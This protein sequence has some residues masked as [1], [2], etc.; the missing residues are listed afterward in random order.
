MSIDIVSR[1]RIHSSFPGHLSGETRRTV[2]PLSI[3]D[4]TV[5]RFAPTSAVWFYDQSSSP[6]GNTALSSDRLVRSLRTTL[7]AY[8][9]WAGQLEF[10]P[11]SVNTSG[12]HTQRFGRLQ[13]IYGDSSVDPGVEL[14]IARCPSTLESLVPSQEERNEMGAW[15]AGIIGKIA[16]LPTSP[17]LALADMITSEGLPSVIIQITTFSC[18]GVALAIKIAHPL[19]DATA[20]LQFTRDWANINK[21]AVTGSP[22]HIPTP[23]FDPA[24]LDRAAAGDIDAPELDLGIVEQAQR[25]PFHRYDWWAS[26]G[27]SC[28]PFMIDGTVVPPLLETAFQASEKGT[29]LPWTEWKYTETVEH[30][31]VYF[32]P[33]ELQGMWENSSKTVRLSKLE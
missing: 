8:P 28:P 4:G 11:Y 16:L 9:Q 7:A 1:D 26:S 21:K 18:G 14:V 22:S 13:I 19:A 12:G 10:A 24:A 23:L 3:L 33:E 29:S 31:V 30:H 25:L 32:S 17:R 20:L 27:P 2:V 5:A 15:N 6:D